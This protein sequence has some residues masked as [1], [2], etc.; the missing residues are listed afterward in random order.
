M[1]QTHPKHEAAR[2]E[3]LRDHNRTDK[4]IAFIAGCSKAKVWLVRRE[5]EERG[6][7]PPKRTRHEQIIDELKRWEGTRAALAKKLGISPSNIS[8]AVRRECE[9]QRERERVRAIVE[10]QR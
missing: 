5:L 4:V 9:R 7:I 2:A 10:K 6:E 1:S 8:A 3:L